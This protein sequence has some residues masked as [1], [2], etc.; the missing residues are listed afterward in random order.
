VHDEFNRC[1]GGNLFEFLL[2]SLHA[3]MN[4][5]GACIQRQRLDLRAAEVDPDA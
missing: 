1:T 5:S 4:R 2:N 3:I